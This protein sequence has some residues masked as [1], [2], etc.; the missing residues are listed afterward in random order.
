MGI[1]FLPPFSLF[2]LCG[3]NREA[4][5]S[6]IH[7]NKGS[8]LSLHYISPLSRCCSVIF[9]SF[10]LYVYLFSYFPFPFLSGDIQRTY[11]S[12]HSFFLL[13]RGSYSSYWKRERERKK[14]EMLPP[15]TSYS[16]SPRKKKR[17]STGST[18]FFFFCVSIRQRCCF[19]SFYFFS[20]SQ[21]STF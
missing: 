18:T 5:A 14:L 11:L 21:E 10:L 12:I 16:S 4:Y 17:N 7:S 3:E 2:F 15:P 20:W 19:F 9:S 8:L 6:C 13:L 1:F